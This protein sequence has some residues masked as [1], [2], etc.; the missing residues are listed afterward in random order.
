MAR[1]VKGITDCTRN[2]AQKLAL[3]VTTL[4]L[5]AN[6]PA[7]TITDK[8]LDAWNSYVHDSETELSAKLDNPDHFISI[9]RR[10]N[11]PQPVQFR[12]GLSIYSPHGGGMPVPS[13]L[14]H[15]W[16]GTVFIPG[17]HVHE[18]LSV[19]QDYDDYSTVYKPAVVESK[20]LTQDHD[21]FTYRLKFVQ[22]GFG[23]KA[24]LVGEFK[25][26]YRSLTPDVGYSVTEATSLTELA[27]VGTA[28]ERPLLLEDAHGYVEKVFTIVRYRQVEGGIYV[29]VETLTLSRD[30]PPAVRWLVSPLIQRFSHHTMADTLEILRAKVQGASTT[31]SAGAETLAAGVS[32]Q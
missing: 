7:A 13:G 11:R 19:L 2:F 24:G 8:T 25:S 27:D 16:F 20:V 1:S 3:A 30:V 32:A 28:D 9:E 31:E 26:T 12:T 4:L 5:A 15:H 6:S 14:V 17:A 23:V 22:K 10:S 29:E 21:E 18:L